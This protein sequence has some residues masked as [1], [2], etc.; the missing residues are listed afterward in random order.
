MKKSVI[1]PPY[2]EAVVGEIVEF[3]CPSD[4]TVE[5]RFNGGELPSNAFAEIHDYETFVLEILYVQ[6]E[7]E[8]N[9]SCIGKLGQNYYTSDGVLHVKGKALYHSEIQRIKPIET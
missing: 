4:E 9:Y 5:W 8:G 3:R 6:H 2:K 7:N 1:Y